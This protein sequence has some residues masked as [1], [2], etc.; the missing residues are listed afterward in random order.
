MINKIRKIED[1]FFGN[2]FTEANITFWSLGGRDALS[3]CMDRLNELGRNKYNITAKINIID[4]N[5]KFPLSSAAPP[6]G[7]VETAQKSKSY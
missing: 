2:A 1:F 4:I 6:S 7:N 5:M 3:C